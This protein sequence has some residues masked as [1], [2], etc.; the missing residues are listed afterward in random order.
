D[1]GKLT[2]SG[3]GGTFELDL[4]SAVDE[5]GKLGGHQEWTKSGSFEL[6]EGTY[7]LSVTHQNIDMPH[8]EYNQSVCRYSVTVTAHGDSSSSSSSSDTPPSSL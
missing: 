6:S 8:N 2:I 1:W 7:T 3:P 4:T 5:P